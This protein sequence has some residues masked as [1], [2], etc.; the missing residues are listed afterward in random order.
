MT[1]ADKIRSNASVHGVLWAAEHAHSHGIN[2]DTVLLALG[3]KR[4]GQKG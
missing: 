2:I 3:F 1:T 4:V